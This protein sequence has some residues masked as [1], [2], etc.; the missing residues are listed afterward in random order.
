MDLTIIK[1]AF[2]DNPEE[3]L[4]ELGIEYQVR[5]LRLWLICPFHSDN[6]LGNAIITNGRFRC[7]ACGSTGDCFSLV[8][9]ELGYTFPEAVKYCAQVYGIIEQNDDAKLIKLRLTKQ[10]TEALSLPRTAIG[11]SKVLKTD[12]K[13]YRSIICQQ[14][15]KMICV[16]QDIIS[17]FGKRDAEKAYI[18]CRLVD[19]W[20]PNTYVEIT[21]ESENRIQVLKDLKRRIL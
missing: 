6:H 2:A 10:E 12:E 16:Y 17:N 14:A 1:E 15:D 9:Q 21:R 5:N 3:L 7:F 11:L 8:Q 4:D 13:A 18:I 19:N 20:T